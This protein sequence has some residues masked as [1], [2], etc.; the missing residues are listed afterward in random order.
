[1]IFKNVYKKINYLCK[2][3]GGQSSLAEKAHP[4]DWGK[5]YKAERGELGKKE[6][7]DG[8]HFEIPA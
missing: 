4:Q 5:M 1:M 7:L 8:V 2:I 3:I 6:F